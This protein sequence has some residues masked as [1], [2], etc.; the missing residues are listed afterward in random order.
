MIF[1][2]GLLIFYNVDLIIESRIGFGFSTRYLIDFS[3]KFNVKT[4]S[5]DLNKN[6]LYIKEGN[7]HFKK[8]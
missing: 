6:E 5:I 3:D 4:V 1:Y 2:L 7:I 8:N